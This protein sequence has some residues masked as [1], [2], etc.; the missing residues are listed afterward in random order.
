MR[1]AVIFL[2][3]VVSLSASTPATVV[4]AEA[5]RQA[6]L[7]GGDGDL[8]ARVLSD[9]FVYIHPRGLEETKQEIV[10]GLRSGKLAYE[11]YEVSGLRVRQ[12]GPESAVVTGQ[13]AQRKRAEVGWRDGV[14][15]F[16]AL[17][18][19]EEGTWRLVSFQSIIPPPPR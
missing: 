6:A 14:F 10:A 3:G 5:S 8:L 7:L 2:A 16:H 1:L 18:Q 17:W 13:V 4:E 15:R 12:V 19:R 11:R 9:Q